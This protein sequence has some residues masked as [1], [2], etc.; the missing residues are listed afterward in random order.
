MSL[1]FKLLFRGSLNI[2]WC[3]CGLFLTAIR[4]FVDQMINPR[5][6]YEH[7]PAETKKSSLR[8]IQEQSD[9]RELKVLTSLIWIQ[10]TT[11]ALSQH[12]FSYRLIWKQNNRARER[13]TY[14]N[15]SDVGSRDLE[16]T[17]REVSEQLL[18]MTTGGHCDKTKTG[19]NH[20]LIMIKWSVCCTSTPV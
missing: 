11:S 4:Y 17:N 14:K 12:L 9:L 2:R 20:I 8:C 1:G 10:E 5:W 3:H 16:L 6:K 19:Y 15:L 18:L 13:N 7:Q